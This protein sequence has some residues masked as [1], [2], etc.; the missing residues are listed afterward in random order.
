M[1]RGQPVRKKAMPAMMRV[2]RKPYKTPTFANIDA[3]P[4]RSHGLC[5]CGG[6]VL[7]GSKTRKRVY[8]ETI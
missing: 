8:L 3:K 2:M 5:E 1:A 4:S 7:S 6:G